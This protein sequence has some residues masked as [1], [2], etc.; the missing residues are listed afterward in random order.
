MVR[1]AIFLLWQAATTH[2][3]L[4]SQEYDILE[5]F[6]YSTNGNSWLSQC[7][8]RWNFNGFS[9]PCIQSWFGVTCT[10]SSCIDTDCY[11]SSLTFTSC[12]LTGTLPEEIG[13]LSTLNSLSLG[14]NSIAGTLPSSISKPNLN[15]LELGNNLFS[16]SLPSL[17]SSIFSLSLRR[18]LFSG[19]L[20]MSFG[21]ISSLIS[22]DLRQNKFTGTFPQNFLSFSS[23]VSIVIDTNYFTG[24]I[25]SPIGSQMQSF[26][27]SNNYFEGS[28]PQLCSVPTCQLATFDFGD[29]K[30]TGS[31]V[32]EYFPSL[33]KLNEFNLSYNALTGPIPSTLALLS[34]LRTFEVTSNQLTGQFGDIFRA[35]SLKELSLGDNMF[36]GHMSF[37]A[38]RANQLTELKLENNLFSGPIDFNGA[39][40]YLTILDL[41]SNY[42]SSSFPTSF[43]NMTAIQQLALDDNLFTSSI[44]FELATRPFLRLVDLNS[45]FITGTIPYQLFNSSIWYPPP[46]PSPPLP[47]VSLSHTSL[48]TSLCLQ[49]SN[50]LITFQSLSSWKLSQWLHPKQYLSRSCHSSSLSLQQSPHRNY[51]TPS[52]L[53]IYPNYSSSK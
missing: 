47:L 4:V 42:F 38:L 37:T 29:N 36:T 31:L 27:G 14:E 18:N 34:R 46:L 16:G 50:L 51:P 44:P 28:F 26:T 39:Y 49:V 10:P 30:I 45:N 6:Y 12:N 19:A 40:E 13:N 17:P 11:V 7:Q 33:R 41:S 22:L 5:K 32:A 35:T 43:A 1:L 3:R 48:S 52:R 2:A 25:P 8:Q 9:D 20:P 23:L 53:C 21:N 24:P 15:F